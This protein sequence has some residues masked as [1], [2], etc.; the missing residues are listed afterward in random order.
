MTTPAAFAG[1]PLMTGG[2]SGRALPPVAT[3]A[4]PK[5]M[6]NTPPV[7]RSPAEAP[8]TP[9]S[10]KISASSMNTNTA[11]KASGSRSVARVSIPTPISQLV[12]NSSMVPVAV[13]PR[14]NQLW[15]RASTRVAKLSQKPVKMPNTQ[16]TALCPTASAHTVD[17]SRPRP[18]IV[19]MMARAEPNVPAGTVEPIR[20]RASANDP[21]MNA[22]RPS[23]I[24][25]PASNP[26]T[27]G[28][29][30]SSCVA[31][32]SAPASTAVIA[33]PHA[34]EFTIH[35]GGVD[36]AAYVYLSGGAALFS[37]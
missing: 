11:V 22:G 27:A 7:L 31:A 23:I 36:L 16:A 4:C 2:P 1:Q 13:V 10:T 30:A 35:Q 28:A 20:V 15:S 24:G 9:S 21:T 33:P 25:S 32:P 37:V 8:L 5:M 19:M 6:A 17:T 12:R 29:A 18:V 26:V 3:E 34:E 14:T